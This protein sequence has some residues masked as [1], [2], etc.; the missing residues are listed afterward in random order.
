MRVIDSNRVS[1]G[2]LV[3]LGTVVAGL[4][5]TLLYAPLM[6]GESETVELVFMGFWLLMAIVLCFALSQIALGTEPGALAWVALALEIITTALS[7]FVQHGVKQFGLSYA[8]MSF[9]NLPLMLASFVERALLLW[10]LVSLLGKKH[11]WGIMVA[12]GVMGISLM[13]TALP[14]AISLGATSVEL[15]SSPLYRY[16]LMAA[17]VVSSSA[18]LVLLW[19]ARQTV[20]EGGNTEISPREA[21]LA[22]PPVHENNSAG[23]DFAIG[24]VVLLI[25]IGVTV[26]SMSSASGGGRYVV[27]TGAIGVGIARIVRG[28]IKV[29]RSEQ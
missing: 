29:S 7:E 13:R 16:G 6:K 3:W 10:L 12:V 14:W 25:R 28:F 11:T 19:F 18:T 1:T 26:V 8:V 27:A 15:F 2:L 9:V 23:A 24:A 22:P 4:F 5:S 20:L 21:G 17:S